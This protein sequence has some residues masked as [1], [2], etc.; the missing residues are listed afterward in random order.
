MGHDPGREGIRGRIAAMRDSYL[1]PMTDEELNRFW[2]D[3]AAVDQAREEANR[4]RAVREVQETLRHNREG[5]L[6]MVAFMFFT[7]IVLPLLAWSVSQA[8]QW[9]WG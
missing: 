3:Q 7:M 6:L 2:S 8:I 5:G 4:Y 1:R 9:I